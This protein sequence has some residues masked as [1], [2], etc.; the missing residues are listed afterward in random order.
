[1]FA[2]TDFTLFSISAGMATLP[3]GA[4]AVFRL[5]LKLPTGCRA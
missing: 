1:M 4:R 5:L 2:C 3:S